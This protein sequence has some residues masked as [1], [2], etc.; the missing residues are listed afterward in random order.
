MVENLYKDI[1]ELKKT[2]IENNIPII[3]DDSLDFLT[4]YIEKHKVKNILEVGTA[5]GYSA[6]MMALAVPDVTITTIEKD[7]ERYLKAVKNIKKMKL[8]DRITLIFKD[9]LEV[10][11]KEKF[12]L[13][14]IDAAKSKNKEI[15][16]HFEKNLESRGT[17]ITDN[18]SFHGYVKK[19]LKEIEN[20][21]LRSLIKKIKNYI[22][23]LETNVKYKTNFYDIGDG[24]S[25]SERR[26]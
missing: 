3:V 6:I 2:A 25:V 12:D 23:F 15:F 19:E 26:M 8:E 16:D 20:Y 24:L 4:N 5:V 14:F 17:V 7:Q 13:I 1:I 22:S 11:I 18:I 10:N 21:R 9:A